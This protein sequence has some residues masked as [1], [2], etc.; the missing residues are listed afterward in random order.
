MTVMVSSCEFADDIDAE[1]AEVA[2]RRAEK[3]LEQMRATAEGEEAYQEYQDAY[4]RALTRIAISEK[5]KT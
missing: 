4:S 2:R 5:F 1:R 3:M